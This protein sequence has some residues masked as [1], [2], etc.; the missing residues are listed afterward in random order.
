MKGSGEGRSSQ[1]DKKIKKKETRERGERRRKDR[2]ELQIGE[3]VSSGITSQNEQT[4]TEERKMDVRGCT[5]GKGVDR[6][7]EG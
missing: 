7:G 6:G 2:P 3:S 5:K 1:G 4:Q